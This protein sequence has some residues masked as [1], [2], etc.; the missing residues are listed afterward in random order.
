V[1]DPVKLIDDWMIYAGEV[2]EAKELMQ[3][4]RLATRSSPSGG[5]HLLIRVKAEVPEDLLADES[6]IAPHVATA[7]LKS[8]CLL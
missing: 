6:R 4:F 7:P 5:A 8:V 2:D 1:P 3:R